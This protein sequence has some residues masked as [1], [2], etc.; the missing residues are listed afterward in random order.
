MIAFAHPETVSATASDV[1]DWRPK[2]PDM[3]AAIRRYV[4]CSFRNLCSRVARRGR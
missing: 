2:F 4:R 1:P 3:L